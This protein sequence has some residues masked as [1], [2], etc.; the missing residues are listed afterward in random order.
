MKTRTM[1]A[2]FILIGVML[3]IAG[4]SVL[5]TGGS[6]RDLAAIR[7]ATVRYHDLDVALAEGYE[8]LFDCTVNPNNLAEAMGQHYLNANLADDVL[9][10]DKPE[11]LMYA[12][13][14]D[15]QMQ[16]VGVEYIMFEDAWTGE[17]APEFLGQT[18]ALKSAVGTHPVPNFYEVHAW[19]WKHNPNG[20]FADWNPNVSCQ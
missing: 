2:L 9:K 16:L 11:V 20:V 13:L 15:G 4:S 17:Q 12:A 7:R 5:A 19:V 18:M 6:S 14:P 8:I 1:I 3:S 10:L